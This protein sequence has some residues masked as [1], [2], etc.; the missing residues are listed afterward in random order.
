MSETLVIRLRADDAAQASWMIVDA[1]GARSGALQS[2]PVADA[3]TAAQ[4]RS[5]LLLLPGSDV[6]LA[7]P[8]LPMRGGARLAQAVPYALEEHLASDLEGLHFAV[9]SREPG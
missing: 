4:Q 5:V 7:A 8:E 1:N 6:T 2:G 3:L 9:G